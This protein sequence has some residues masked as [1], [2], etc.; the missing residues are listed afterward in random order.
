MVGSRVWPPGL[1]V[2]C[3]LVLCCAVG[4]GKTGAGGGAAKRQFVAA[5]DR[6]CATHVRA[7]M[8]F[9]NQREGGPAWQQQAS[10]DE[11]LFQIIAGSIQR[12]EGLG[13]APGPR[14]ASFAGYVKTLKAR[15]SLYRLTS[16]AF[17]N[18][19]TVFAL[20]LENRITDID[21]QGDRF[22]HD[23]GLS[24]CGTGV[25]DVSKAFDAAGWKQG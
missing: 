22:A 24:I 16:I 25:R 13:P 12:L 6:V 1:A 19:D 3:A 21:T 5:A 7:V 11:G 23:Y 2:V 4:C 18:R 14:G 10:Q 15:A 17:L 9:L 8:T 20:S